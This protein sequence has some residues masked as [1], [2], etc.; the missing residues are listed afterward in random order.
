MV[1]KVEAK[2]AAAEERHNP[3][4]PQAQRPSTKALT[5]AGQSP[6]LAVIACAYS[7]AVPQRILR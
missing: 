1:G 2:I 6:I 5:L 3:V 4:R 7:L